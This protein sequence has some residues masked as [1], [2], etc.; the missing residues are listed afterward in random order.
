MDAAGARALKERIE[1]HQ[2]SRKRAEGPTLRETRGEQADTGG[3]VPA[4][5][6]VQAES[7]RSKDDR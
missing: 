3:R 6:P 2:A 7:S 5:P 4:V 1:A